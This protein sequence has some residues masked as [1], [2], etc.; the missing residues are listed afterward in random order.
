MKRIKAKFKIET[1]KPRPFYGGNGFTSRTGASAKANHIC[2]I[3]TCNYSSRNWIVQWK[4]SFICQQQ[5]VA[6][7][8]CPHHNLTLVNIGCGSKMPKVGSKDRK[9]LIESLK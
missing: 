9:V 3:H 2:P 7:T 6:S 4:S 1:E 5:S 8:K